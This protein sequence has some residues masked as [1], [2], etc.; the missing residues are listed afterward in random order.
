MVGREEAVVDSQTATTGHPAHEAAVLI[1]VSTLKS[2]VELTVVD[3]DGGS[4]LAAYETTVVGIAL[5]GRV[6]GDRRAAVLDVDCGTVVGIGYEA[7]NVPLV[8]SNGAS[9][10]QVLDGGIA[11]I[12]EG[13]RSTPL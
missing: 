9:H 8:G 11:Y 13:Y 1:T 3:D 6:D 2:T 7:S 5:V 4:A 10:M 12:A